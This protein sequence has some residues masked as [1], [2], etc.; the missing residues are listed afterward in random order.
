M[1]QLVRTCG[2]DSSVNVLLIVV[3]IFSPALVYSYSRRT[4]EKLTR[5]SNSS[6]KSSH[7]LRD[8]NESVISTVTTAASRHL[9]FVEQQLAN[10]ESFASSRQISGQRRP[11]VNDQVIRLDLTANATAHVPMERGDLFLLFVP[12]RPTN[13]TADFLHLSTGSA[14]INGTDLTAASCAQ[15]NSG[16]FPCSN[17][18]VSPPSV[19][20][21][22]EVPSSDSSTPALLIPFSNG[23]LTNSTKA[24]NLTDQRFDGPNTTAFVDSPFGQLATK[25]L[26]DFDSI[27]SSTQSSSTNS[28]TTMTPVTSTAKLSPT[29]MGHGGL[30]SILIDP[31]FVVAV[32]ILVSSAAYVAIA[33]DEFN[34]RNSFAASQIAAQQQQPG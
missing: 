31:L 8:G 26:Q 33:M 34:S 2:R 12:R 29:P 5:W 23:T 13:Q 16:N 18:V 11:L 22:Q 9:Q 27:E 4:E 30:R 24:E 1:V 3:L 14:P 21:S 17:A 19:S 15:E 25:D 20:S 32:L 10:G 28:T 7:V 6:S